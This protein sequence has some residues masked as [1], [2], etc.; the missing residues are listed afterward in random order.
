M[1][2]YKLVSYTSEDYDF[3][4]QAKK[5]AYQKYVVENW[6]SWV[7]TDQ[8]KYFDDF[9]KQFSAGTQIIIVNNKKAGFINGEILDEDTFELGN[10]CL[11]EEFRGKG[12]GSKILCDLI[13][14]HKNKDIY[15]RVFKSNPAKK[16]YERLG[17][18][19]IEDQ[20]YHFKMKRI[21]EK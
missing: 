1:T 19:T 9:I 3:V 16:L 17:F 12:L 21:G 2:E 15:L 10:I 8:Q 7:E 20:K 14:K 11:K 4:Y 5:E 18:K 6:G 13:Q